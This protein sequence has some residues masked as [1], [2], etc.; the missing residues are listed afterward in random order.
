MLHR[1]EAAHARLDRVVSHIP[2]LFAQDI[3][4]GNEHH[5]TCRDNDKRHPMELT[6]QEYY[7]HSVP[8]P[9]GQSP[10]NKGASSRLGQPILEA[11]QDRDGGDH[12]REGWE[13]P[14]PVVALAT[15]LKTGT[16]LD[17]H[18]AVRHLP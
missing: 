10:P 2:D 8:R 12:F 16:C 11:L 4:H 6:M 5:G 18:E 17:R 9:L 15:Q 13:V 7:R 3:N 14:T 1:G